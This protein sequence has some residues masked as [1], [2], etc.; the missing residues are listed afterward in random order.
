VAFMPASAQL[1][2]LMNKS[3]KDS[4]FIT[5]QSKRAG[6]KLSAELERRD[7]SKTDFGRVIDAEEGLKSGY[8]NVRNW[9]NGRHFS[10]VRQR[11]CARLL[12]LPASFF[13]DETE[14]LSVPQKYPH[15]RSPALIDL[16]ERRELRQFT[17]DALLA[18]DK[19]HSAYPDDFWRD[20]ADVHE[21]IAAAQEARA[22]NGLRVVPLSSEP[23]PTKP[24]QPPSRKRR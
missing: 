20:M 23:P 24:Q 4:G 11:M 14:Q 7:L 19:T 3:E 8:Q 17:V 9:C 1:S 21:G 16:L 5:P 10:P 22:R 2:F 15:V 18:L 13:D 12:G 6:E